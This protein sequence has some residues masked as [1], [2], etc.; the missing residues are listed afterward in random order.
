M[1]HSGFSAGSFNDMTRVALLNED[2][3]TE[4]FLD[5]SDHLVN[6]VEALAGRLMQYAKAMREHDET[7][8]KLL[9][10]EGSERKQYLMEKETK[11]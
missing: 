4:L 6:E 2:M 1:Q 3:W 5:N 11:A 9:L 8:L 10:H 7:Q